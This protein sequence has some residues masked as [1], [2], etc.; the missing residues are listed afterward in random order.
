MARPQKSQWEFGELFPAEAIRKVLTVSEVTGSIRR[1]LEKEVG[2]VGVMGELTNLRIQSSG[3]VYFSIKDANAQLGC[4]MFRTEAQSVSR[5]V[6]TEGQKVVVEGEITV[7]EA[8]GQYQLRVDT[9][10]P[11]G[12]G[13]LQAA[14]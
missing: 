5:T 6:F 3:H 8:R 11:Q 2:R 7:Y 12:V 13:A 4:V 9:I 10:Q 1:V 14:F